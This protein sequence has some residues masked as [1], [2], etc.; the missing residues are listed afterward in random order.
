VQAQHGI[1]SGRS[2]VD[3][4][5]AQAR[6]VSRREFD[7][8]WRERVAG[9]AAKRSS[10]V[11]RICKAISFHG[12]GRRSTLDERHDAFD[13]RGVLALPSLGCGPRALL[14]DGLPADVE[15]VPLTLDPRLATARRARIASGR[16]PRRKRELH[17]EQP[18]L[19]EPAGSGERVGSGA[20]EQSRGSAR[21]RSR[22]RM[23]CGRRHRPGELRLRDR[24]RRRPPQTRAPA[25][26]S[27]GRLPSCRGSWRCQPLV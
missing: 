7:V 11:R 5:H 10:G 21:L 12:I 13:A 19:A 8:V 26:S 17:D 16:G 24:A 18:D 20:A 22:R 23:R 4:V 3:V 27:R 6:A 2:L 15:S 14:E 9:Q 1:G 25:E